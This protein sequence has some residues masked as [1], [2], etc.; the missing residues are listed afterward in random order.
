MTTRS[1]RQRRGRYGKNTRRHSCTGP[2]H[3]GHESTRRACMTLA[4]SRQVQRCRHGSQAI[5]ANSDMQITQAPDRGAAELAPWLPLVASPTGDIFCAVADG[6]SAAASPPSVPPPA[7]RAALSRA[8]RRAPGAGLW[9]IARATRQPPPLGQ[10]WRRRGEEGERVQGGCNT[11][12]RARAS[13][14]PEGDRG[15]RHAG[16]VHLAAL[17]FNN[18]P[19]EG[20]CAGV[21][22]TM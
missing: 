22:R 17:R 18:E 9:G 16:E 5:I 11:R 10:L 15:A 14:D 1:H 6:A 21:P 7:A 12:S 3:L 4:H 20:V 8:R 13:D 2:R 19:N